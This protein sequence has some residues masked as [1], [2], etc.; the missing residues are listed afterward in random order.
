LCSPSLHN[1]TFL[2]ELL[3]CEVTAV[4]EV[5]EE[6]S[7]RRLQQ[8]VRRTTVVIQGV[9]IFLTISEDSQ[10]IA[11]DVDPED[12][13]ALNALPN[14]AAVEASDKLIQL[15]LSNLEEVEEKLGNALP[16]NVQVVRID[17]LQDKGDGEVLEVFDE[18]KE[19]CV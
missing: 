4:E 12:E 16:E 14:L 13:E 9:L 2:A 3:R 18:I 6:L 7:G 10:Q 8:Q 11:V 17:G 1:A 19:R 15:V 5:V